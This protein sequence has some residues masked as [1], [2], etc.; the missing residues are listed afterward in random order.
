MT[1]FESQIVLGERYRDS[2]SGYEGVATGVAFF[3]H[4][5]ERVT[6]EQWVES[7]GDM[8]ELTF[9]A[10]RLVH[11]DTAKPVRSDR[12]GGYKPPIP[13]TGLRP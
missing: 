1:G 6:V 13:R 12:T 8:R 10:P 9:D 2:V 11:V 7:A 3:L 5:C 4:G